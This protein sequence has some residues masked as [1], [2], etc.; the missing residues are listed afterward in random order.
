MRAMPQSF[1]IIALL[2]C[3]SPLLAQGVGK[4]YRCDTHDSLKIENGVPVRHDQS[5]A[6]SKI[7][8]QVVVDTMSGKIRISGIV[9]GTEAGVAKRWRILQRGGAHSDFVA[10]AGPSD[11]IHIRIWKTPISFV[12]ISNGF[13]IFTGRCEELR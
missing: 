5:A 1:A 11:H 4:F 8:N 13:T 12:L 2:T 7:I 9:V 10:S 3:A 6:M